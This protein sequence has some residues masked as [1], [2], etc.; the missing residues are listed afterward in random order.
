MKQLRKLIRHWL[1]KN[2]YIKPYA[3]IIGVQPMA[4]PIGTVFHLKVKYVKPEE[5]VNEL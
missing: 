1:C 3:G 2:G 5:D 4:A